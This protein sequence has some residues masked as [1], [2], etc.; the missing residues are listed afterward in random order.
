ME[1]FRDAQKRYDDL[2]V[3]EMCLK[4]ERYK[5]D[6]ESNRQQKGTYLL[7]YIYSYSKGI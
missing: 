2:E 7:L 5:L 6:V 4:C 3:Q 1:K